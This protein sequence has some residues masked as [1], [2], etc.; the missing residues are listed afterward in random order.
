VG[1]GRCA[2]AGGGEVVVRVGVIG[3]DLGGLLKQIVTI[4]GVIPMRDA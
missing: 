3:N 1:L 2:G 4:F